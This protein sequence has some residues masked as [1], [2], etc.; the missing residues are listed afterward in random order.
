MY[1]REARE[2]VAAHGRRAHQYTLDLM[3]DAVRR[4]EDLK[5]KFYE[6]VL[7]EIERRKYAGSHHSEKNGS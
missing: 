3:V 5:A 2:I 6:K 7:R 4:G 1:R